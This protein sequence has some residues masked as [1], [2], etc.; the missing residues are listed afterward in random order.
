MKKYQK[1]WDL[2]LLLPES[3]QT[4][5]RIMISVSAAAVELGQMTFLE[6]FFAHEHYAIREGEKILTDVWFKYCA[7]L[8]AEK[9]NI[10]NPTEKQLKEFEEA[11]KKACPPPEYIDFR[12]TLNESEKYRM[13]D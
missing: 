11:A 7:I 13:E 10:C 5:D 2:Y 8:L 9:N 6:E 3:V 1:A 4:V 12:M